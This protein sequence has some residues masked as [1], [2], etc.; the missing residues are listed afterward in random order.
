M[1]TAVLKK[2]KQEEEVRENTNLLDGYQFCYALLYPL[3]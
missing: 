2:R 1:Q 3:F